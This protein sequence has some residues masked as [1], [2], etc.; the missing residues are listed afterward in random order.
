MITRLIRTAVLVLV[1]PLAAAAA[2]GVS[3]AIVKVDVDTAIV[4]S[5]PGTGYRIV[6]RIAR[7][8]RYVV[9]AKNTAGTWREIWWK[10]NSA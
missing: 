5:G 10:G 2:V 6:G 1:A 4:R 7:G 3:P 8:A 9:H